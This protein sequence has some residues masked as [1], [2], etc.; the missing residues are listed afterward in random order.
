MRT[1]DLKIALFGL[2][3]DIQTKLQGSVPPHETLEWAQT[4]LRKMQSEYELIS[5]HNSASRR[6]PS[7]KYSPKP[8]KVLKRN[9]DPF[10]GADGVR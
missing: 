7:Q 9:S 4:R 10:A 2:T 5:K 8:Y 6:K 3:N 1:F